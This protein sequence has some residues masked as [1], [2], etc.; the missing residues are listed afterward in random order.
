MLCVRALP[1]CVTFRSTSLLA[2][3]TPPPPVPDLALRPALL[4]GPATSLV[5]LLFLL[6]RSNARLA[7]VARHSPIPT[8]P[9]P[10]PTTAGAASSTSTPPPPLELLGL[11]TIE[12]LIEHLMQRA[13]PGATDDDE[14]LEQPAG[15]GGTSSS[16]SEIGGVSAYFA[17][18]PLAP[19]PPLPLRTA[20]A[21][22]PTPAA[23]PAASAA[24][25]SAALPGAKTAGT[26]PDTNA[27]FAV[28]AAPALAG[29]GRG[30]NEERERLLGA[31]DGE[32]EA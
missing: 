13:L 31:V 9:S 18:S 25:L 19:P 1:V 26:E 7:V 5:D 10:T 21:A 3:R 22:T 6:H 16:S 24:S 17:A 20:A 4:V 2:L 11:V 30:A 27:P 14:G 28:L 32:G 8:P 29:S 12:E 23:A 15:I